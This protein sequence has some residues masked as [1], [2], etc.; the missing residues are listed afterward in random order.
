MGK[1]SSWRAVVGTLFVLGL[2]VGC[3]ADSVGGG[4][5]LAQGEKL[6]RRTCSTCHGMN[7]QGIG[8]LG[9]PLIDNEFVALNSD[10]TLVQFLIEGRPATHPDNE[11]GVDMP[12]RGGNPSLT[13]EDLAAI[14]AYMRALN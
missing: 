13:D 5:D 12:P 4:V 10:G 8:R 14:V 3:G 1:A 11:R 2:T 6:F 7:G 9:N